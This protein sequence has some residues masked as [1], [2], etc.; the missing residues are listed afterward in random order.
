MWLAQN[1]INCRV[2]VV[3]QRQPPHLLAFITMCL[4]TNKNQYLGKGKTGDK[5]WRN[6]CSYVAMYTAMSSHY[7]HRKGNRRWSEK[8]VKY[9]WQV[10]VTW[11]GLLHLLPLSLHP[12]SI[13]MEL[14]LDNSLYSGIK[15]FSSPLGKYLEVITICTQGPRLIFHLSP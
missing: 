2:A 15:S 14:G 4:S 5:Q 1:S 8:R 7:T 9:K 6:F 3:F 10:F 12:I 13:K 11:V